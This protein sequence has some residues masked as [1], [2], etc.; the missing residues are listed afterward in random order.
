MG[1]SL[2]DQLKKSG[3]IDDKKANKVK[4]EKH[5]QTKH[6]KGKKSRQLSDSKQ[7]V[8][9]A[10]NE[11][12]ARDRKLNDDRKKAAEQQAGTA[13][14]KQLIDMNRVDNGTGDIAF[15]FADGNKIE[16]LYVTQQRRDQLAQGHLAIV[17]L[18]GNY[19][20]VPAGIAEKIRLREAACV[21]LVNTNGPVDSND[22][23]P[24][25]EYQVPDDLVW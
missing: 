2:L 18:D 21:I 9:Q 8:Q 24:Y 10:L 5:K 19:D 12:T 4:K 15:N 3:L 13:Q 25:A 23:D 16:R 11:K 14:I 20:L 22:D 6:Q 7:R 17:K 1:N